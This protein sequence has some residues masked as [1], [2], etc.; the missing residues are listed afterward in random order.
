MTDT[1]RRVKDEMQ[2][3]VVSRN[4]VAGAAKRPRKVDHGAGKKKLKRENACRVCRFGHRPMTRH[5][6]VPRSLLGDDVED[7]LIPLCIFCHEKFEHDGHER[8]RVGAA[9]RN[10]MTEAE[11]AY[12]LERK[13]E[14]FL[15][16][17]YPE[18]M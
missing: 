1:P 16:R 6:L 9:I 3:S 7:N 8:R 2:R 15:E 14:V 11:L 12:V 5:H 18:A 4:E 10:T 13:G 17:Y